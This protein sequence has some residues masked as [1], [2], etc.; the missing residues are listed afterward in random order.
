[1]G[2]IEA[3]ARPMP[4]RS[5]AG[6]IRYTEDDPAALD[7]LPYAAAAFN[8]APEHVKA[9][10]YAAFDIQ[11]LYRAPI[12]QATIWATITPTTPGIIAALTTDPRTDNAPRMDT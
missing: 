5:D 2:T 4:R 3:A 7:E 10:I 12:K 1:M 6:K 9:R 11:V 8:D